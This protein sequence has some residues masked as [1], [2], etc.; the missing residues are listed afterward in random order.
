MKKNIIHK[1]K[2]NDTQSK[3]GDNAAKNFTCV[4]NSK[5]LYT[6]QHTR[7]MNGSKREITKPNI[8]A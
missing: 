1:K 6:I 3:K 2:A 4:D 5:S 8:F 7:Q